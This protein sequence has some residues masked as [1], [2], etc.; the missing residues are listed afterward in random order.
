MTN[1]YYR[2]TKTF[3]DVGTLIPIDED[4][5]KHID[6]MN[7]PWFKSIYFY[8]EE[9]K[10]Q[11]EEI[12]EVNGRKR[13]RGISGV[14][15]VKTNKIIFD[16]DD[17]D[18]IE[19]ARQDSI[20]VCERLLSHGIPQDSLQICFSGKKGFGV[21][22]EFTNEWF[23][24]KELKNLVNDFAHD[25]ET[26]DAVVV[27]ASRIFR[28]PLT[29]HN[30]T[31]YY[32]T[33]ISFDELKALE[34]GEIFEVASDKY[35][36]DSLE[37]WKPCEVPKT[38][39]KIKT[40]E[41]EPVKKVSLVAGQEH[42]IDF[43]NMP[44]GFTKWKYAILNGYF[45][46]GTR[47]NALIILASTL[48]YLGYPADINHNML[49]AAARLQAKRFDTERFSKDD[50]WNTIIL[51]VY[52][53]TWKGGCYSEESFPPALQKYL[54]ECGVPKTRKER[55]SGL[56]NIKEIFGSFQDFAENIDKNTIKTGIEAIDRNTRITTGMLFG[57]LA[58]AG[59][60]KTSIAL[61][62]L[63][64]CSKNEEEAVFFSMDMNSNLIYQKLGQKHTGKNGE[65]IFNVF[66][67]RDTKAIKEISYKINENYQNASFDFRTALSVDDMRN[68]VIDHEESTGK[69]IKLVVVDY[70]ECIVGPYADP[71]ANGGFVA[72]AL[73]DM[74]SDLDVCVL[75]L[76]QT[77]KASGDVAEPLRSMRKVKG[78]SVLEQACS[79]IIS[80]WREGFNPKQFDDDIFMTFC[81]V[82][83]R[84]GRLFEV[85]CG[86]DGV[87]GDVVDLAES[88]K[89]ELEELRKQKIRE[90]KI[91]E[92]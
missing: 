45:P 29:K 84:M 5:Y 23:N 36:P 53:P 59:G 41:L 80:L 91:A 28:V 11:A 55:S 50:I 68:E 60:G 12:V 49:K 89:E 58:G 9:Q 65:Q 90:K 82:K 73:K 48:K 19:K 72:N 4:I 87:T 77:Q 20:V 42:D 44:K 1:L 56:Q 22:V 47:S 2:L 37:I 7:V 40:I 75:L 79:I 35:E 64:E 43:S 8:T 70:L 76:L 25:L 24:P 34:I 61:S 21:E 62:I 52:S 10:E 83:N 74:A 32:K 31:D 15:D 6:D 33:P 39:D 81:C 69:K 17:P 78:S 63:N 85:D 46:E 57:L 26:F 14:I 51:Q 67:N 13:P 18:D 27:N 38:F 86:W 71:T 66:K 16:F 88:E 92:L 3:S 54:L 30:S